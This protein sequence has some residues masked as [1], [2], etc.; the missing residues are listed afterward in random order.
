MQAE[1]LLPSMRLFPP[2]AAPPAWSWMQGFCGWG[3]RNPLGHT[4]RGVVGEACGFGVCRAACEWDQ[5]GCVGRVC[6]CVCTPCACMSLC[7]SGLAASGQ[8]SCQ[9]HSRTPPTA[10]QNPCAKHTWWQCLEERSPLGLSPRPGRWRLA[11]DS[12]SLP[13]L[14]WPREGTRLQMCRK[15][16][17]GL[18]NLSQAPADGRFPAWEQG[19]GTCSPP[20]ATA[21]P[22]APQPPHWGPPQLHPH[23]ALTALRWVVPFAESNE[24]SPCRPSSPDWPNQGPSE[25]AT[26]APQVT[27]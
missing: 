17:Q 10:E 18:R 24:A 14:P 7:T 21:T 8:V 22:T 2:E 25:P 20:E 1:Q 6:V 11:A 26:Q 19:E 23:P 15:H 9:G 16:C 27:S 13:G 5:Y 4:D 12:C 3:K